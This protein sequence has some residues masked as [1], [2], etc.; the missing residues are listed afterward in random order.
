MMLSIMHVFEDLNY[1]I[2]Q[3]ITLKSCVLFWASHLKLNKIIMN[4][5]CLP[6]MYEFNDELKKI[7]T[8]VLIKKLKFLT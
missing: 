8:N 7:A 2:K 3:Y 6:R 5:I 1:L 4:L